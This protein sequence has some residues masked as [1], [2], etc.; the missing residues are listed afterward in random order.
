MKTVT[1]QSLAEQVGGDVV[2]DGN[3]PIAGLRPLDRAG[4]E[5]LTFLTNKKYAAQ[6]PASRAAAVLCA[7]ELKVEGKP[8][9]ISDNPYLAVARLMQLFYPRR[10]DAI[11][12]SGGAHVDDSAT[13][14]R[15]ANIYP[16][17]VVGP[18]AV[19]GD[20]V[21]VYPN[22]VIGRGTKIGADTVVYGGVCIYDGCEIGARCIVHGGT[23][24]GSDGFG[25][26]TDHAAGRHVK[27]PQVGNVI[28]EDDVEIGSNC[29]IDRGAMGPTRIGEGTKIDNLVHVAHNVQI[30]KHCFIA[31]QTGISGSTRIGDYVTL[32]GQVGLAGHI[33]LG[34]RVVVGAKGGV[35]NNV[36][37]GAVY[38]GIP[39]RP[40]NDMKRIVAVQAKLPEM[41]KLLK[42]LEKRIQALEAK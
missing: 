19:L 34:D 5:H 27:I 30:G 25:F 7:P 39:A 42:D 15:D 10:R 4:P 29:T 1:L 38:W 32:A 2:G 21:D 33:E 18:E 13:I 17:A 8:L 11:G 9:L 26:A 24:I 41:R 12:V 37:A 28:I 20:R 3:T 23:V 22:S 6:A 35:S 16:G 36:P 31:G 14:G 40:M